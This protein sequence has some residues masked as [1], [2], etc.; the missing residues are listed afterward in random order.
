M[1]TEEQ[2]EEHKRRFA[3][4]TVQTAKMLQ[5][6]LN[7]GDHAQSIVIA[8]QLSRYAHALEKTA[9]VD[10]L[11]NLSEELFGEEYLDELS[12]QMGLG[13]S[14]SEYKFGAHPGGYA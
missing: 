8:K 1:T 4:A 10:A 7:T 11:T 9:E 14:E 13:S 3:E 6:S 2:M 5:D 12:S